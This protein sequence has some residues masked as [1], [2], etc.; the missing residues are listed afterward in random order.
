M[1]LIPAI[2]L[3]DGHCVRLKQGDMDQ[4][5]TFGEDPAAIA[6]QIKAGFLEKK[7][8][9]NVTVL[10][11]R[12]E[13]IRQAVMMAETGDMVVIAGK[14]HETYQDFGSYKIHFD[15]KEAVLAAAKEKAEA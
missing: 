5:T 7:P 2:D 10:L 8:D 14:G 1:L 3:K 6:E 15:D 11:D 9:G 4:S 13:A 12:G